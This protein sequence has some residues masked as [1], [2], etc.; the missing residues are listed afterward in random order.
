MSHNAPI[1]RG[2]SIAIIPTGKMVLSVDKDTY[3]QLGLVG[4]K[5]RFGKKGQRYVIVLD[6]LSKQMK[7]GE[8]LYERVRWCFTNRFDKVSLLM[9]FIKDGR[10]QTIDLPEDV[11]QLQ[12]LP[13]KVRSSLMK[14]IA[15]PLNENFSKEVTRPSSSNDEFQKEEITDHLY[16]LYEWSG[17]VLGG[18]IDSVGPDRNNHSDWISSYRLNF[19]VREH[20]GLVVSIEGFIPPSFVINLIHQTRLVLQDVDRRLKGEFNKM[21]E[22]EE[23]DDNEL[24]ETVTTMGLVHVS[25][26]SDAPIGWGE[27]EHG[28]MMGGENDFT[29]LL[30]PSA[31]TSPSMMKAKPVTKEKTDDDITYEYLLYV[32][33]GINDEFRFY[34]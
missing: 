26:F 31:S 16:D 33:I 3:E 30:W 10:T 28:Y 20:D 15:I 21:K 8:K 29:L 5:S 11:G 23:E 14:S 7:P 24:K 13:Y 32:A 2:N 22:D 34:C 17:M 12:K 27:Y 4:K 6:L 9:S 18:M 19:D 25:G 1:D